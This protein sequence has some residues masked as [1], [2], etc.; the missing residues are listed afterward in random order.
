MIDVVMA[1]F[2]KTIG[3]TGASLALVRD[4]KL[5]YAKGFGKMDNTKDGEPVGPHTMFRIGEVSKAITS[6]TIMTMFERGEF[7]QFRK[8]TIVDINIKLYP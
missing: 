2:M 5:V 8:G 3:I 4:E 6:A 7:T 1:H